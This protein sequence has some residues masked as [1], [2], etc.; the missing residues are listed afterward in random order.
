M[1]TRKQVEA[2]MAKIEA[3]DV[4]TNQD[5]NVANA[6][7]TALEAVEAQQSMLSQIASYES[8]GDVVMARQAKDNYELWLS[9]QSDLAQSLCVEA[10]G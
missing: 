8:R 10:R 6:C 1:K 2:A 9:Q 3:K 7:T 4:R 5:E